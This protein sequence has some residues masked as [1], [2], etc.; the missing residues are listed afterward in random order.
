MKTG[1]VLEIMSTIKVVGSFLHFR[2]APS[3][4]GDS[5][6]C[7]TYDLEYYCSS[8]ASYL[9]YQQFGDILDNKLIKQKNS[10]TN[11]IFGIEAILTSRTAR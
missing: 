6:F 2:L 9:S 3:Y 1:W 5:V 7:L 4:N 10:L 8:V 11:V